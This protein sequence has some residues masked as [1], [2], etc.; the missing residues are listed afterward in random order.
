MEG[1]RAKEKMS[2]YRMIKGY[3]G[4]YWIDQQGHIK[5]R[6]GRLLSTLDLGGGVRAI[7]LY[8]QGVRDR[9]LINVLLLEAFPE[10]NKESKDE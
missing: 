1:D 10:I 9:K 5:N 3:E 8:G 6:H 7:D 4:R 2:E